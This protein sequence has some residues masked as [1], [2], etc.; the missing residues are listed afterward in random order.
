MKHAVFM[1]D[2]YISSYANLVLLQRLYTQ[3]ENRRWAKSRKEFLTKELRE[4]GKLT[5]H[6]CHKSNLKMGA[7]KR[8]EQATVDH[9]L[10]QSEGGD[11]Y[12]H[13]NFV[14][15]CNSCNAKKSN[16]TIK[17]FLESTYLKVKLSGNS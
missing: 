16:V 4:K 2:V 1:R 9:V 11:R 5:C 3:L 15:C 10:A 12:D 6:Y 13:S 8:H 7:K 14:V 17:S